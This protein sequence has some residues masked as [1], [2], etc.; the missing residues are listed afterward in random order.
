MR[1]KILGDQISFDNNWKNRKEAN[2]NHWTSLMPKNQI[3]LAFRFHWEVF[4]EIIKNNKKKQN[5][6]LEVG[7]GRGSLSSY[8]A[9]HGSECTLLD[10]SVSVLEKARLVFKN[11]R[12]KALFIEGDANKLP[13]KENQFDIVFSIGL[14]EH[15]EAIKRPIEE[16]LKV[17]KKGGLLFGYI[18]P[19]NKTNIQRYF[20]WINLILFAI[21]KI[22][23]PNYKNKSI[24]KDDIFRSNKLSKFYLNHIN[25]KKCNLVAVHGMYPL[26]MISHS[27]S[28]PFSLLP[29]IIELFLVKIFK[30]IIKIRSL[31]NAKHGWICNEKYGQAF[32]IVLEK[33]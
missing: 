19:E 30:F 27:A 13:F 10:S 21:Y 29:K 7:C 17:L 2:Y 12:H 11:N 32:L 5:K 4:Q 9:Q 31:L 26:P 8:F 18:V 20:S 22:F 33:K 24:Q 1:K 25:F 15:F 23:S 28:F 14:L 3:Q 6:V 16:Q